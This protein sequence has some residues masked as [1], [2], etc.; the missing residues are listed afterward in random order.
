MKNATKA[1]NSRAKTQKS[2]HSLKKNSE[3][4]DIDLGRIASQTSQETLPFEDERTTQALE[5]VS[6]LDLAHLTLKL[7]YRDNQDG[8]LKAMDFLT[9]CQL[10]LEKVR[11][12][13]NKT[14][15][16]YYQNVR[17]EALNEFKQITG[18]EPPPFAP[19]TPHTNFRKHLNLRPLK[20]RGANVANDDLW[21]EWFG[22]LKAELRRQYT[23][24]VAE[25]WPKRHAYEAMLRFFIWRAK[26]AHGNQSKNKKNLKKGEQRPRV[27]KI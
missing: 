23:S 26:I 9:N 12:T 5:N 8:L 10:Q 6:A 16:P 1:A 11:N 4:S 15:R 2:N 3:W 27:R 25:G 21:N 17:D 24:F 19:V 22:L 14:L 20:I 13:Y 7:G 18:E